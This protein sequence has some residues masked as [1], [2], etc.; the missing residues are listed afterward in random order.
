VRFVL[1]LLQPIAIWVL[2]IL[3]YICYSKAKKEEV[4]NKALSR[5]IVML[6]VIIAFIVQPD[7]IETCLEMFK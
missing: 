7:L 6:F 1:T 3:F 5:N 2:L 4:S